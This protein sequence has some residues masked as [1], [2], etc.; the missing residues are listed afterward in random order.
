MHKDT[1]SQ[2]KP[3]GYEKKKQIFNVTPIDMLRK[4]WYILLNIN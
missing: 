1:N 3:A 4:N 2:L